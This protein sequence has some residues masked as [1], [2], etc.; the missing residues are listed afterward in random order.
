MSKGRA[1]EFEIVDIDGD[2]VKATAFN[3]LFVVWRFRTNYAPF[4][5]CM[6]WGRLLAG[7]FPQGF[8]VMHLLEPTAVAPDAPTRRVFPELIRLEGLEHYS[9]VYTAAGFRGASIRAVIAGA[10]AL[11]RPV[12]ANAVHT[13][14]AR[15]ALWHAREQERLGRT[16][17]AAQIERVVESLRRLHRERYPG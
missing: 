6:H 3:M 14:V 10:H 17:N 2:H 16:E 12:C 1:A 13:D 9:V 4:R 5:R 11:A 8:G 7:Q 15:A